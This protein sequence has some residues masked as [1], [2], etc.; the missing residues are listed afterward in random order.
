MNTVTTSATDTRRP[1]YGLGRVLILIYGIFA[2]SATARSAVQLIRNPSEATLAYVLS[3]LAA[4]I[5]ILATISLAH[6]GRRMRRIAWGAV[7][8]EAAGVLIVGTLSYLHPEYFPR[9]TVWSHF[10]W[11]YGLVPLV[12]PFLGIA[13]LY[14]SNPARIAQN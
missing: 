2:L 11:G 9:A 4:V 6:N 14:A 5:Y 12:L 1:A 8:F 3:A 7:L 13:W 10:G